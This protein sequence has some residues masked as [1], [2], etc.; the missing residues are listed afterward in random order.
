[1]CLTKINLDRQKY[2]V[3]KLLIIATH[4]C[5]FIESYNVIRR[6]TECNNDLELYTFEYVGPTSLCFLA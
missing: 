5:I 3:T 4:Y 2:T 1:M 6:E